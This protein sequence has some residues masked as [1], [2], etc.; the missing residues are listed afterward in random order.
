MTPILT[1]ILTR[2]SLRRQYSS[3]KHGENRSQN[4]TR[5]HG[6]RLKEVAFTN[7]DSHPDRHWYHGDTVT[8][9]TAK[10]KLAS[11]P[12]CLARLKPKPE[13]LARAVLAP[14]PG[15]DPFKGDGD[16]FPGNAAAAIRRALARH[17]IK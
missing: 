16:R 17:P 9:V 12:T 1:P 5:K 3:L 7:I 8:T 2:Q 11:N 6:E 13:R 10:F 14:G 4:R 15:Q